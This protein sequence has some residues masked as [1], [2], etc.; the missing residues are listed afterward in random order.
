VLHAQ[1]YRWDQQFEGLVAGI[2]ADF[3][4]HHD[5]E[6]ERCWIAERD[7][8]ILGSVCLVKHT[9]T[10]AK[11]RLLLVEPQARGLGLGTRLVNECLSF[12]RQA[13]YQTVTLWTTNVLHA[14]RRIY[15]VAGFR[16]VDEEPG[17]MF[18]HDL[19]GQT[20]ELYL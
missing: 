4:Q 6:H 20:W 11:L 18:G 8:E 12:A 16:L 5:P 19:V 17:H 9:D 2:V 10:Q 7:G 13:G 1:E 15:E 14:A 3:I